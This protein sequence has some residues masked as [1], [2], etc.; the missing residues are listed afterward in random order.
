VIQGGY[1]LLQMELVNWGNFSGYQ[2]FD[3]RRSGDGEGLFS[4]PQAS[5]ILGVNGSG[6]T[7]LIDALMITLLPFENSVKLGVTND[8]ES[9]SGGGRTIKDYVLGKF[10]SNQGGVAGPSSVFNREKG[11]SILLLKFQHNSNPN[12]FLTLGR[13]WWYSQFK[14]SE[15]QLGLLSLD[16]V[17]VSDI[18]DQ[19]KLPKSPKAFSSYVKSLPVEIDVYETLQ[20]YF[21]AL[22]GAFGGVGRSDFKLLNRAFYVK[23]ISQIDSFIKENMLLDSDNPH[24][25]R[26]LENVRNGQ[27]IASSIETC[28]KKIRSAD[29]VIQDLKKL[30]NSEESLQELRHERGI[31]EFLP[32]FRD[33]ERARTDLKNL[34]QTLEASGAQLPEVSRQLETLELELAL[35][36]SQM[37]SSDEGSRISMLNRQLSHLDEKLTWGESLLRKWKPRLKTYKI[38]P[39]ETSTDS[40]RIR[41]D[42][43]EVKAKLA[44]QQESISDQLDES[45]KRLYSLDSEAKNLKEEIEHLSRS[46]SLIPR[47]IFEIKERA[48][49]ELGIPSEEIKFFSEVVQVKESDREFQRPVEAVF[50]SVARNLLCHPKHLDRLTKWLNQTGLRSDLVVKRIQLEDLDAFSVLQTELADTSIL[51]Y[52]EVL[53]SQ[54]HAFFHYVWK[55]CFERFDYQVVGVKDFKRQE[56]G[57][58][59]TLEGL[60]K[61]D[62]RT[63]KKLKKDFS[64]SLGWD[65]TSVVEEKS[66]KLVSLGL[67]Y[68]QQKKE[69]EELETKARHGQ[70]ELLQLEEFLNSE[71]EILLLCSHPNLKKEKTELQQALEDLHEK[72]TGF[73]ALKEKFEGMKTAQTRLEKKRAE[74]LFLQ[75]DASRRIGEIEKYLPIQERQFYESRPF[76]EFSQIEGGREPLIERLRGRQAELQSKGISQREALARIDSQVKREEEKRQSA[77]Q[78]AMGSLGDHQRTFSDS[79]V[80]YKL[81]SPDLRTL[82]ESWCELKRLLEGTDLPKAREK[83]RKF[84]DQVLID[85]VKDTLNEIKSRM[86]E[87][88][89]SIVKINEVLKLV[90]FEELP[91]EQRY[92]QIEAKM[93]SEERVRN[94]RKTMQE[95]EFVLG[96]SVRRQEDGQSETVMKVLVPFVDQFQKEPSYRQF[97]TDVRNHFRF[98]VHSFSRSLGGEEDLLVETFTGAR[99]DAKSS[100]QTTQLAYAL[101]ASSLAYRFRF[102]DPIEGQETPR[103]IIFDEFGGKF[104]NEKPKEIIKLMNKMGFQSILLSPMS[105]ADLLAENIGQ[106][107]FVHKLSARKSKVKSFEINSLEDYEKLLGTQRG[108]MESSSIELDK[109]L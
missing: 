52:I 72:S 21:T 18:C 79:S 43:G 33:L 19:G 1:S 80:S 37:E 22:S 60:V 2:K 74:N 14:V 53:P 85:S 26:L 89:E 24:L 30:Q 102:H 90:N 48:A 56:R 41:E 92:L 106:M 62:I 51:N 68:Q 27:E 7:T 45:R 55:W 6:K 78:R 34:R 13:L 25:E 108:S 11:C 64:Y 28:E 36:Q 75:E 96:P 57:Q 40:A 61:S 5:A 35:V 77:A 91:T 70:S 16:S 67:Q 44:T 100:A 101:L 76:L 82:F 104:D 46:G 54:E 47:R 3:L 83:W 103:L 31:L 15:T 32:D 12:R 105:K 87:I 4:A 50:F 109:S 86:S 97:V 69:L 93:S 23:S 58:L 98:Q 88:S 65:T 9:G 8:Y 71:Q 94:F 81:E 39:P 20:S 66:K 49:Q 107:I 10:A 95:L 73:L 29:R 84:F 17:S 99:K 42:I 63:M 59:V 38:Q